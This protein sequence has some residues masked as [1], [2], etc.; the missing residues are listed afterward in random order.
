LEA[1]GVVP[2]EAE[3]GQ[4]FDPFVHEAVTYEEDEDCQEGE[5]IAVVQKGYTL[6][7]RTLRPAMVR[8]AK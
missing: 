8:V 2:V 1:A 4:P 7:Q 5:I 6:N 3:P